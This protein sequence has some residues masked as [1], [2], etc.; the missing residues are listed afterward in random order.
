MYE[1]R[2]SFTG[3][4]YG[5]VLLS[6]VMHGVSKGALQW[7]SRCYLSHSNI[8]NTIVK[9]FLKHSVYRE[10][11]KRIE[12]CWAV[13]TKSRWSNSVL[14]P[15]GSQCRPQRPSGLRRERF[16]PP[17]TLGSWGRI[18]LKAWISLYVYSVFVMS[19]VYNWFAVTPTLH[20]TQVVVSL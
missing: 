1:N 19:G 10:L 15:I 7:Y 18:A 5:S 3:D 6:L 4:S 9:L 11:L 2:P 12:I 16:S 17:K 8:W 13:P 20:E 14:I